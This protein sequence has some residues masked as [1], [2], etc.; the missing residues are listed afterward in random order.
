MPLLIILKQ[1]CSDFNLF[2]LKGKKNHQHFLYVNS[3]YMIYTMKLHS[4]RTKFCLDGSI[5][6]FLLSL[7]PKKTCP[8]AFWDEKHKKH[9]KKGDQEQLNII[10]KEHIG[11]QKYISAEWKINL[12]IFGVK[13]GL[14]G[15][16]AFC[17]GSLNCCSLPCWPSS[18]LSSE[19]DEYSPI[20][21]G[22]ALRTSLP[23]FT[24]AVHVCN[25]NMKLG[26]VLHACNPSYLG[27]R[28]RKIKIQGHSGQKLVRLSQNH[29]KCGG[30]HL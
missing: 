7:S 11:R 19:C 9:P 15:L 26:I 28:V 23:P 8:C 2:F 6:I 13:W 25:S 24:F 18:L 16:D 3:L 27:G 14:Y 12:G 20:I 17:H 29:A 10:E 30:T 5:L 22:L 21:L 4:F 1:K